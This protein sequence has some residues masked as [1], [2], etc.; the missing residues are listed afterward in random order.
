MSLRGEEGEAHGAADQDRV[1]QLAEAIDD[2]NLV[3]DLG[4]T[5]DGHEWPL[6]SAEQVRQRGHL[7]LQEEPRGAALDQSRHT[8]GGGVS[9]VG[10]AEG[11]V[12]IH[13]AQLG[14]CRRQLGIVACLAGLVTDVLEH[15]HLT[16]PQALGERADVLADHGGGQFDLGAAELGETSRDRPQR[17]LRLAVLG[18]PEV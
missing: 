18:P 17:E 16:R 2:G 14:Q 8:L 9:A 4:T 3:A 6:R 13:V 1:G 5:E 7:A 11:V 15:E 12:Y 10:G